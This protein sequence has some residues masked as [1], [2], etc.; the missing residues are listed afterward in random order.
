MIKLRAGLEPTTAKI[1]EWYDYSSIATTSLVTS[2]LG[3]FDLWPHY[4]ASYLFLQDYFYFTTTT[5]TVRS[6]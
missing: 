2:Y 6:L 4:S 3:A 5:T 1:G